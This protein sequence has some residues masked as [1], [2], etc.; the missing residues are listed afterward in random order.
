MCWMLWYVMAWTAL[1]L[2]RR[3]LVLRLDLMDLDGSGVTFV[4]SGRLLRDV[5]TGVLYDEEMYR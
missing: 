5:C 1:C 3:I 4:M 2:W